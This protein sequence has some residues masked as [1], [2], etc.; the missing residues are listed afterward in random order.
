MKE[1]VERGEELPHVDVMQGAR[2]AEA[3]KLAAVAEYV[4]TV[5]DGEGN[6]PGDLY[7]ELMEYMVPRWDDA[8]NRG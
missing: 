6:L 3:K 2:N 1:R 4:V 5:M 8:R 7:I